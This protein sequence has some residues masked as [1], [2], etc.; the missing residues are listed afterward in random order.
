MEPENKS[1]RVPL[2]INDLLSY[3]TSFPLP[4]TT[5]MN[6]IAT[7]TTTFIFLSFSEFQTTHHSPVIYLT[8]NTN[9]SRPLY[10][11]LTIASMT[12]YISCTLS[13]FLK[14]V[15]D[16]TIENSSFLSKLRVV[17][18]GGEKTMHWSEGRRVMLEFSC[19]PLHVISMKF[20][21]K[22]AFMPL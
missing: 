22:L 3:V 2:M 15:G 19:M 5:N 7:I 12:I 1:L 21:F 17:I 8:P 10:T 4:T 6:S 14:L 18:N 16:S 20:L 11:V 9:S 13:C